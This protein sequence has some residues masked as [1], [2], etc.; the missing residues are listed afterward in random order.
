MLPPM[1]T[2]PRQATVTGPPV[3]QAAALQLARCS[4]LRS[5]RQFKVKLQLQL[6]FKCRRPT[7]CGL[8]SLLS[9]LAPPIPRTDA[10]HSL[11]QRTSV[12]TTRWSYWLRHF[13]WHLQ[14]CYLPGCGTNREPCCL[15]GCVWCQYLCDLTIRRPDPHH[16]QPASRRVEPHRPR[17]CNRPGWLNSSR[18][19][20]D[21]Q[22]L[23]HC[24]QQPFP[25]HLQFA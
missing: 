15:P 21:G 23:P 5:Q 14:P 22:W 6:H 17:E 4:R 18:W 13:F 16:K 10:W 7:L 24:H 19:L 11:T 8:S 12:T 20:A 9:A 2:T 1:K 25:G 3:P